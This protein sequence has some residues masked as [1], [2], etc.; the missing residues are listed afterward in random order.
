MRFTLPA[1]PGLIPKNSYWPWPQRNKAGNAID[2]FVQMLGLSFHDAMRL[3]I[4]KRFR[5][6]AQGWRLRLPWVTRSPNSATLKGFCQIYHQ[7][8]R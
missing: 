2:F 4:P 1:F 8:F 3:P 6:K 5:L 7:P